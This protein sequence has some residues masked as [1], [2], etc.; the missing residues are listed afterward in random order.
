M[1]PPPNPLPP[2]NKGLP[3]AFLFA[4]QNPAAFGWGHAH[5]NLAEINKSEWR[6]ITHRAEHGIATPSNL[7]DNTTLLQLPVSMRKN[8]YMYINDFKRFPFIQACLFLFIQHII[9]SIINP[10]TF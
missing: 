7:L 5:F 8:K 10:H 3:I 1:Q 4:S 2:K 9:G 6:D